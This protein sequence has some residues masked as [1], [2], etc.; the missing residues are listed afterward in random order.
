MS[1]PTLRHEK[2]P[3]KAVII[4]KASEY[5]NASKR[6]NDRLIQ[7]NNHYKEQVAQLQMYAVLLTGRIC[8]C[9][10]EGKRKLD[11]VARSLAVVSALNC[12]RRGKGSQRLVHTRVRLC[13]VAIAS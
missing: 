10:L 1:V 8:A 4:K 5:V 2:N 13:L 3:S 12:M 11:V 6:A 7:E 9:M